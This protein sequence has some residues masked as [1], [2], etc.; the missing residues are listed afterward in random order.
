[1]QPREEATPAGA[2]GG[3]IIFIL[4]GLFVIWVSFVLD[5]RQ[6]HVRQLR[7]W[8][9]HPKLHR[10]FGIFFILVGVAVAITGLGRQL[11]S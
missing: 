9:E 5:P 11:T 1:M 6:P 4:I 7:F 10:A 2:I 8:A 3:G